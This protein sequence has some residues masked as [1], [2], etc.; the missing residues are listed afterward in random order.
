MANL[1]LRHPRYLSGL[2]VCFLG[3]RSSEKPEA[4]DVVDQ[5]NAWRMKNALWPQRGGGPASECLPSSCWER[6]SMPDPNFALLQEA[7]T[8]LGLLLNEVVFV[9]GVTLGL[10]ITDDA[11]APIRGTRDVDVMAEG[12]AVDKMVRFAER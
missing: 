5:K 9:G 2:V 1:A 12:R 7:A 6:L 3:H 8:K 11:T 4:E 10:L